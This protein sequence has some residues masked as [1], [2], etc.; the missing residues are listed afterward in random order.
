MTTLNCM[1]RNQ[2]L[3]ERIDKVRT[4]L[5]GRR[6]SSKSVWKTMW[7]RS[8]PNKMYLRLAMFNNRP[9]TYLLQVRQN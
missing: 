6:W 2:K 7:G 5:G 3:L 9:I 1:V 4:L 8:C